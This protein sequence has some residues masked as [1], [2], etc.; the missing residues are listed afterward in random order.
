MHK[1]TKCVEDNVIIQKR[2]EIPNTF[3]FNF[4]KSKTETN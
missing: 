3:Q 2:K 1:R 4:G